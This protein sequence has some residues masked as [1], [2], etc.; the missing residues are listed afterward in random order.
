MGKGGGRGFETGL[1]RKGGFC[2]QG[3]RSR[4]EYGR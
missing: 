4:V 2:L 3:A 1:E